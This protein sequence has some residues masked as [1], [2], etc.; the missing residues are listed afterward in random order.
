MCVLESSALVT[1]VHVADERD[2]AAILRSGLA[3]PK[4]RTREFDSEQR[5][6][7]VFA[8]P[9]IDDFLLTHQWVRELARRGHRSAVGVYFRIA[10]DEQVW[11]GSYNGEKRLCTAAIA[12]AELRSQRLLGYEVVVPRGIRATEITAL[13]PLP[14]VGW[15][16]YPQAKGQ[17]PFCPCKFCTRGDVNSRRLRAKLD[18]QGNYA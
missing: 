1:L 10:D 18:P 17:R 4:Q 13:R 11:A 12:A 14:A 6:Y 2:A 5:K 8:M 7:G 16:F 15:R 3:L 9:V